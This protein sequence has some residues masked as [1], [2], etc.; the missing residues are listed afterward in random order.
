MVI[1]A[2]AVAFQIREKE[3]YY[4]PNS[5]WRLPFLGGVQVRDAAWCVQPPLRSNSSLDFAN[6]AQKNKTAMKNASI[7]AASMTPIS[8]LFGAIFLRLGA[9]P[10]EYRRALPGDTLVPDAAARLLYRC[11]CRSAAR[12]CSDGGCGG[13]K[14]DGKLGVPPRAAHSRLDAVARAR[15]G[16]LTMAGRRGRKASGLASTN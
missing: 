13:W 10:E 5:A 16:Q 11:R 8:Y 7:K 15:A 3:D 9:T 2:R 12:S 14:L 6:T 1:T 4:Y